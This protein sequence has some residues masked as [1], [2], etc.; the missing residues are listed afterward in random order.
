[1]QSRC[2]TALY[3]QVMCAP[4]QSV[5]VTAL[6]H[7]LQEACVCLGVPCS[8]LN[9]R[10]S[11]APRAAGYHYQV[12]HTLNPRANGS[13]RPTSIHCVYQARARIQHG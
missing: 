2:L 4:L 7:R 13:G 10:H 8:V 12:L 1:M 6:G 3:R 11:I 5:A 9:F